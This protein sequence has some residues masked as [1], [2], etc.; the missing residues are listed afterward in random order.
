VSRRAAARVHEQVRMNGFIGGMPGYS[1]SRLPELGRDP[2][3]CPR[4]VIGREDGRHR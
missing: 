1:S 4:T 2:L 3:W